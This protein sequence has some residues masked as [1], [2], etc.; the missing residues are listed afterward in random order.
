[1]P[2]RTTFLVGFSALFLAASPL[3]AQ[4]GDTLWHPWGGPDSPGGLFG[5]DPRDGL[6]DRDRPMTRDEVWSWLA[7]RFEAA[8]ADRD[9]QVT[10]EEL[11]IVPSENRRRAWFHRADTDRSGRLTP[12]ELQ[13]LA[14]L[15]VLHHD[16]NHDGVL[17]P[18]EIRR[19]GHAPAAASHGR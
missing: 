7:N 14:G 13:A 5:G 17:H 15:I 10:P 18:H 19:G 1:M 12:D 4:Q 8:D 3:A 6:G 9:L 16:G 11:K 2:F